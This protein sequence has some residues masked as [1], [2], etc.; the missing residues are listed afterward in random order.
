[1][2]SNFKILYEAAHRA[3]ELKMKLRGEGTGNETTI[4]LTNVTIHQLKEEI[5]RELD[6]AKEF[7]FI[8]AEAVSAG[9]T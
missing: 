7:E 3:I 6:T 2:L 5:E 4:N 8:E 1:M 9:S